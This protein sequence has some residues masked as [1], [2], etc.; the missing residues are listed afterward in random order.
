VD[1]FDRLGE[2]T[3]TPWHEPPGDLQLGSGEMHLWRV[4]LDRAEDAVL[5]F[6]QSLSAEECATADRFRFEK[7][8]RFFTVTRGVLRQI[9]GRYTGAS[10]EAVQFRYSEHGKPAVA[11]PPTDIR[12]NVSHSGDLAVVALC[13]GAEIGVDIEQDDR[14]LLVTTISERFFTPDEHAEI[15]RQE[16]EKRL[17]TFLRYWTAKEAV[18]K[19]TGFGMSLEPKAIAIAL[20]PLQIV[21]LPAV[22]PGGWRLHAFQP[23]AGFTGAVAVGGDLERRSYFEWV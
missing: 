19:A 11:E 23:A 10:P 13:L 2:S 3:Q 21:S 16:D 1:E 4:R 20:D 12:F 22:V 5:A 7:H 8:R 18:M 17:G 6:R 9:I 14:Q 15:E